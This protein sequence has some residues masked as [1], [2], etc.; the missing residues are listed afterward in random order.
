MDYL[1]EPFTITVTINGKSYT[2]DVGQ[3]DLSAS[4][5]IFTLIYKHRIIKIQ[6]NRPLI[7]KDV[8]SKKKIEWKALNSRVENKEAL[9]IIKQALESHIK[10]LEHPPFDWSTHPKNS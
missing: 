5:E 3:T 10:R 1:V 6:S 4:M 2:F 7:T 8:N 9:E